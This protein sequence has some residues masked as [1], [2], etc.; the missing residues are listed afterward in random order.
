MIDDLVRAHL[1]VVF[2]NG[3]L[4]LPYTSRAVPILRAL[5]RLIPPLGI[6]LPQLS[7]MAHFHYS[8]H[9]PNDTFS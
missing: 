3:I 6:L 9:K 1:S 7:Y 5:Q 8:S 4:S 2:S